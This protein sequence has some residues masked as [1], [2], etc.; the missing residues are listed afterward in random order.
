MGKKSKQIKKPTQGKAV[1]KQPADVMAQMRKQV[2]SL[3]K[4]FEDFMS[5]SLM[6]PFDT[7]W[8]DTSLLTSDIPAPKVDIIDKGK[9]VVV[10]AEVP[11][12][13]KDNIDITVT[14]NSITLKGT[15]SD[16]QKKED[17]D[18]YQ[19]EVRQMSFSRSL[20]LPAEVDSNN[21]KAKF[22]NGI[23]EIKLPKRK[24]EKKNK[25]AI[26]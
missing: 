13:D 3:E 11:G 12:F 8:P 17:G 22:K 5:R 21:A 1:A 25:V 18:F 2:E 26:D 6:T 20:M 4:R 16:E 19:S 7:P 24:T 15:V 14:D 23:L 9:K 10:R